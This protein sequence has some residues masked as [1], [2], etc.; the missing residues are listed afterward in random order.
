M[1]HK[2]EK[3]DSSDSEDEDSED[4]G[5]LLGDGGGK[6]YVNDMKPLSVGVTM[7]QSWLLENETKIEDFPTN[8]GKFNQYLSWQTADSTPEEQVQ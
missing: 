5:E 3:K 8:E 4:I 7:M 6:M 2:E 1:S